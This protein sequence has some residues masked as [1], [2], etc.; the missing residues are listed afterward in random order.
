MLAITGR[1]AGPNLAKMIEGTHGHPTG[2]T[3]GNKIEMIFSKNHFS[4]LSVL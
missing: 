1:T 2:L 4:R 3:K